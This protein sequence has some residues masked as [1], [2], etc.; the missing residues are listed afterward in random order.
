M[1]I[2]RQQLRRIIRESLSEQHDPLDPHA[3][4]RPLGASI[5]SIF[6]EAGLTPDEVQTTRNELEGEYGAPW[7]WAE[8]SAYEKLY[9]HFMDTGEMPYGVAKARTGDPDVWVL[10]YLEGLA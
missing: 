10:D 1:K 8:S 4:G 5:Q 3:G 9:F 2:T 7:D 6:D